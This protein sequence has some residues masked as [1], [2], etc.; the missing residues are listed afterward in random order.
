MKINIICGGLA[1]LGFLV[2]LG[3]VGGDDY[4]NEVIEQFHYCEMV[5]QGHWPDYDN[6]AQ[7]CHKTRLAYAELNLDNEG[8]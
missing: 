3:L 6:T 1:A 7:Y 8:A 5:D 4:R 2:V